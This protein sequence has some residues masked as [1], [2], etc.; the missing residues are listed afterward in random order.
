[1]GPVT[2]GAIFLSGGGGR[3]CD[4][5]NVPPVPMLKYALKRAV[6]LACE[7]EGAAMVAKEAICRSTQQ[8]LILEHP[9]RKK[10][11]K[12]AVTHNSA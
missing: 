11:N 5:A 3:G 8:S 12:A 9:D 1:M 7:A 4:G 10:Q 6:E 2:G